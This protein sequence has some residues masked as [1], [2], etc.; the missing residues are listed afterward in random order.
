FHRPIRMG[1]AA[2]MLKVLL[3]TKTVSWRGKP[4][5]GGDATKPPFWWD[6]LSDERLSDG[7]QVM[8]SEMLMGTGVTLRLGKALVITPLVRSWLRD[9]PSEN[10]PQPNC[11]LK[12]RVLRRFAVDR[13][14]S[15]VLRCTT[16]ALLAK[17]TLA[18][19]RVR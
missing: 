17:S 6:V 11:L 10:A 19:S 18:V 13:K 5:T 7:D 9:P 16:R 2:R 14:G 15:T 8:A 1:V 3:L 12:L 4:F